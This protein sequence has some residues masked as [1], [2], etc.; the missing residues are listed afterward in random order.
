M[1][2]SKH[3]YVQMVDTGRER[4]KKKRKVKVQ[5]IEEENVIK[6]KR[7]LEYNRGMS[8][9]DKHDQVFVCFPIMRIFL[10]GCRKIFFYMM[11]ITLFSMFTNYFK[12]IKK[13][14]VHS[15]SP[16]GHTVS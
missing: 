7:I 1:L 12:L 15:D 3:E 6:P 10:K 16:S 5:E 9:V 13:E 14:E 8:G 2:S 11:D 4:R